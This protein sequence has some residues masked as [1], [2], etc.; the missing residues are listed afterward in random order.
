[1]N[2]PL[3]K[4]VYFSYSEKL[5]LF[6][7]FKVPDSA[8]TATALFSGVKTRSGVLGVDLNAKR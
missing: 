5:I 7:V 6:L 2:E 8:G 3:L 4:S 1:M